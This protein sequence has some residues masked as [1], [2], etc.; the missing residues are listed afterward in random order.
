MSVLDQKERELRDIIREAAADRGALVAFS[1]GVDSSLLLWECVQALG[2]EQ[3]TAVTAA[4]DT[5][6]SG[7]VEESRR[8]AGALGVKHLVVRSDEC[9]DPGFMEN[10]PDRCYRCKRSRYKLLTDLA[11]KDAGAVVLDG[12]QAD[13]DP[14][15]RP[16]MKASAE[17]GIPAPLARAGIRKGEVRELLRAAGFP[18]IARKPAQPC[19]ATRIP[20]GTRITREALERVRLGERF[21]KDQGLEVYRLRDHYPM[22]RIKTDK[23]G[24]SL[25]LEN[26]NVRERICE[27][28]VELGYDHVTLDLEEYGGG[29]RSVKRIR[30]C[31]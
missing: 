15:D 12:T 28:L 27:R 29:A 30:A 16:G 14:E 20:T 25:I 17:L 19:L 3:V 22:A 2:P 7:E 4:S 13:D 21:L 31:P 26:G 9:S 5:S 11:G 23:G 24:I 10:L 18:N 1:G 8:F 6:V